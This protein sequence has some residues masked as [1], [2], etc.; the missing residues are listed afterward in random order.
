MGS[1]MCIRD[2]FSGDQ[3][4]L[5]L[6]QSIGI[7]GEERLYRMSVRARDLGGNS[8]VSVAEGNRF[9]AGIECLDKSQRVISANNYN[10]AWGNS[11][12]LVCDHMSIDDTWFTYV[13]Y[14]KGRQA[15]RRQGVAPYQSKNHGSGGRKDLPVSGKSYNSPSRAIDGDVV[16]PFGTAFIRPAL[17]I[18]EPSPDA[19]YSQGVMQIDYVQIEE[20]TPIQSQTSGMGGEYLDS[21]SL[22]STRGAYLQDNHYRQTYAYD[23]RSKQQVKNYESIVKST[24]HPAGL[25]MFGTVIS[26]SQANTITGIGKSL[27]LIHI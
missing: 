9:S 19:Q 13:G 15:R 4:H 23:I 18:N 1:E 3:R 22:L 5:V 26:E 7:G 17:R 2:R 16:L 27:S 6:N 24:T 12:W 8:A 21:S 14:F 10:D 20:L 11:H 25:K